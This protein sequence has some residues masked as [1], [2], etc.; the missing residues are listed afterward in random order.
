MGQFGS[1]QPVSN[2]L[3]YIQCSIASNVLTQHL[4]CMSHN[5]LGKT[6]Y[7]PP[8][9]SVKHIAPMPSY[10]L[11]SSHLPGGAAAARGCVRAR[12]PLACGP[13]TRGTRRQ[14]RLIA[15]QRRGRRWERVTEGPRR[16]A[17]SP[18]SEAI[19]R[20][21][22]ASPNMAALIVGRQPSIP[23]EFSSPSSWHACHMQPCFASVERSAHRSY[24]RRRCG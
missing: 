17:D 18:S 8:I 11:A 7:I 23:T 1:R 22:D 14:H 19:V 24:S 5:T 12:C 13:S 3:A 9:A 4:I 10:T 20:R 2:V 6:L 16:T 15:Q 21:A